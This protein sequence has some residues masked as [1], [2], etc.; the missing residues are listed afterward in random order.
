MLCRINAPSP[1]EGILYRYCEKASA[2]KSFSP[3][4]MAERI[5]CTTTLGSRPRGILGA[6]PHSARPTRPVSVCGARISSTEIFRARSSR[7]PI[8]MALCAA[9]FDAQ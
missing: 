2:G 6:T 7:A 8:A 1:A 5:L 9:A 4:A 3:F